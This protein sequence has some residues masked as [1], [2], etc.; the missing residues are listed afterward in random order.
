MATKT[1]GTSTSRGASAGATVEDFLAALEHPAKQEILALRRLILAADASIG[2]EIKWKVPSFRTA[3]HFAT[4][5]LRAKQ[6]VGVI[7]HFGAKKRSVAGVKIA[8]PD[9]LLEWLADDRA[10]ITFRDL[11]DVAAKQQAFT[12]LI[13]A[14]IRHV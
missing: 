8:D 14:W 4:L 2:E 9:A 10:M 5:H 1:G 11:H 3:G 13:R 7:L 6:G 12:V